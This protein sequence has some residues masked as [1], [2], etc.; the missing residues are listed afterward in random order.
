MK[1]GKIVSYKRDSQMLQLKKKPQAASNIEEREAAEIAMAKPA[2]TKIPP[3][4]TLSGIR[5]AELKPGVSVECPGIIE[6]KDG[7]FTVPTFGGTA[8]YTAP[9]WVMFTYPGTY[10]V[11]WAQFKKEL[12]AE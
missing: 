7:T 10:Q 2:Q 3:M 6:N 4:R 11:I 5:I 9:H 12:F 8:V 1:K